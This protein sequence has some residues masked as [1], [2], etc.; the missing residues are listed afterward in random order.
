[1]SLLYDLIPVVPIMQANST[2]ILI[3]TYIHICMHVCMYVCIERERERDLLSK[4]GNMT[5][6]TSH[7]I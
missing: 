3:H 2:E 4:N 7:L 5:K 6:S 1:L